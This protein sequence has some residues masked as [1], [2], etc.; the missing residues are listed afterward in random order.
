MKINYSYKLILVLLLGIMFNSCNSKSNNSNA[1]NESND[2]SPNKK[3]ISHD[4]LIGEWDMFSGDGFPELGIAYFQF[5]YIFL[6]NEHI[7]INTL[8][9]YTQA[10]V[11]QRL[12]ND[13]YQGSSDT[14][15]EREIYKYYVDNDNYVIN[16]DDGLVD[17][18]QIYFDESRRSLN[19]GRSDKP[20]Y[21]YKKTNLETLGGT[22]EQREKYEAQMQ[23][24]EEEYKERKKGEN[25][26]HEE[27]CKLLFEELKKGNVNTF[28]VDSWSWYD[29]EFKSIEL[30]KDKTFIFRI[31][32]GNANASLGCWEYD[33]YVYENVDDA[34]GVLYLY[35]CDSPPIN[36]SQ[37]GDYDVIYIDRDG[38]LYKYGSNGVFPVDRIQ[39]DN[40]GVEYIEEELDMPIPKVTDDDV[41]W[42]AFEKAME[43]ERKK[44]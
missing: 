25:E 14:K 39:D 37:Q 31:G 5:N 32:F 26:R 12:R 33:D 40:K 9:H 4:W 7:Q 6:D 28:F 8:T 43:E 20:K 13:P 27:K 19:V 21:I 16:Y 24:R 30:R 44:W 23:Q 17:G 1:V 38:N 22:K 3:D 36:K 10:Y 18:G 35:N 2:N 15:L 42:E 41:D 11:Q 29:G 34:M